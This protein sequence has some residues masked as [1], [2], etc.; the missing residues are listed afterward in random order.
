MAISGID[1]Q[2][3]EEDDEK[4]RENDTRSPFRNLPRSDRLDRMHVW[5]SS[6]PPG[7]FNFPLNEA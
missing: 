7:H 6:E 5:H 3:H 2:Y 1:E 4:R